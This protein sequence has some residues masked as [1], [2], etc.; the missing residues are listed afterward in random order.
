MFKRNKSYLLLTFLV[1]TGFGGRIHSNLLPGKERKLLIHELKDGKKALI[2]NV[3]GLDEKQ[4]DFRPMPTAWSIRETVYH[5][6]NCEKQLWQWNEKAMKEKTKQDGVSQLMKTGSYKL[7]PGLNFETHRSLSAG[8]SGYQNIN[9]ALDEFTSKR[10]SLIK[11]VRT[12]TDDIRTC[13]VAC[14]LGGTDSYNLLLSSSA[15]T[16]K[17]INEIEAIKINPNFPK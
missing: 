11:F 9:E 13:T 12:T 14:P 15:H 6:A 10:T 1:L 7:N 2:Q 4:L 8:N 3:S 5:L 17:H 16:Q